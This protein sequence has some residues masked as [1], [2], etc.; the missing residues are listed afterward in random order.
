SILEA[1]NGKAYN[2]LTLFDSKGEQQ[3]VYRK[4][5]LFRLMQEEK[6]LAPGEESVLVDVNWGKTGLAICYDLRFVELFRKYAL[7]GA[8]A[9]IIPAEWPARRTAHWQT[10]LRARAI[11]NQMVVIAVNRVG[12]SNGEIFGGRSAVI[13]PW[14]EAIVEGDDQ[15]S[16]LHAEIDMGLVDEVRKRIPI[17]EDRREDVY[18]DE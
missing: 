4:I 8:K 17:F 16:L 2:T 13:D 18:R 12:E 15:Q 3:A 14:G 1:R 10:L 5:H 6:W 11:E 7:A 9:I